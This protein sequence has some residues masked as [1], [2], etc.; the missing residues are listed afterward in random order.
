MLSITIVQGWDNFKKEFQ[1]LRRSFRYN[2]YAEIS[3]ANPPSNALEKVSI[4]Q[5]I[6]QGRI[7]IDVF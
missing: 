3:K 6:S 1:Q 7:Q 4:G 5:P 2:E